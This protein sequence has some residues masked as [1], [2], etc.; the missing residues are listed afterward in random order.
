MSVAVPRHILMTTDAVGGVWQYATDLAA[1]LSAQGNTVTLALLGPAPTADQRAQTHRIDG[2]RL[3]E[4]GLPLDWLSAGAGPVERAAEAIAALAAAEGADLIHCNMPTLAGAASFPV[5][6]VA[7]THG[8][9]AT[10]W[11]AARTEPL[12]ATYRWH[13][14]M[15]ARGLAAADVVVAP[16][17][18]YAAI[19]RRTY[20]LPAAPLVVHNGRA[21]LPASLG[22]EPPL[23]AA[24]TVGRLWDP[25]KNAAMLDG[26]AA[27]LAMPFLAAGEVL[28]PHGEL[29][30]LKHLKVL[31]Q[32]DA[33]PLGALLARGPIFVSAASFEPFGLAV[34]EAAQAGCPLILSDIPTF[35]ELW[36]G[37][38][39]FVTPGDEDAFASAIERLA[40]DD[41]QRARLGAAA[42]QRAARYTPVAKAA[43][44]ARIYEGLL[45]QR[46]EAA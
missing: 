26:I 18:S 27:H 30:R 39:L 3:V 29:I 8:C 17:A 7:V 11:Q 4:T 31:G 14:R 21:P 12:L 42:T 19:V 37:A 9:I 28:G 38:A 46:E 16:S 24:L 40:A 45:A 5:P 44:M 32:I 13:K 43:A 2:L 41:A 10:W 34:L 20:R 36:E 25:V 6:V 23:N 1:A 22:A 35:R 33:A 15:M